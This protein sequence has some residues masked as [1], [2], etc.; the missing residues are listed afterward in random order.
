[1]NKS[2]KRI[3]LAL[4]LTAIIAFLSYPIIAVGIISGALFNPRIDHPRM[5]RIFV[6]DYD[7]LVIVTNYL[8]TS[9]HASPSI[10]PQRDAEVM[11]VFSN[12]FGGQHIPISDENVVNAV[13]R[14]SR[15]GYSS[16]NKSSGIITFTR[17]SS[18][19]TGRGILYSI[20]GTRPDTSILTFFTMLEPLSRSGWFFYEAN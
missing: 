3:V 7:L 4:L 14:L 8:I 10:S 2:K 16:I 6:A 17:W 5:E 11:F 19:N 13:R 20:D 15:R 12:D 9:G 1:M 18:L